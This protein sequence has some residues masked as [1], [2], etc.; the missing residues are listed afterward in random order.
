MNYFVLL[1]MIRVLS[2]V[3]SQNMNEKMKSGVWGVLRP[4][5]LQ[6]IEEFSGMDK[7]TVM[8]CNNSFERWKCRLSNG[9]HILFYATIR[10]GDICIQTILI[11]I[12]QTLS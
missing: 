6:K 8:Q 5:N 1:H 2:K 9:I 7:A 10:S 3:L 11:L 4:Q 12:H